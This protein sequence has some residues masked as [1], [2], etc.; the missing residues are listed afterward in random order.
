MILLLSKSTFLRSFTA[1][2]LVICLVFGL[3]AAAGAAS[4]SD[5]GDVSAGAWYYDAV[6]FVTDRGLFNGTSSTSFSPSGTMT[7]GMFITVLGRYAGVD[8]DQWKKAVVSTDQL[9]LRSGP[10][11][12]YAA[13]DTLYSGDAVTLDGDSGGWYQVSAG[14]RSGYVMAEYVT[15]QYHRFSDV[16]YGSYYAGYAIW[17]FEAGIVDGMGSADTFAPSG[18]VTREQ[19]CK[20]LYGY[21]A[22]AGIS[23]P[24]DGS[25]VTFQDQSSVSSWAAEGVSAMQRAG[26]VMGEEKDGGYVFRPGSSATRA[27]AAAIFQRFSRISSGGG[28]TDPTPTPTQAP[29]TVPIPDDTPATFLSDTVPVRPRTVRVGILANTRYYSEAAASVT[30]ENLSGSGFEYGY[31]TADRVFV[32][33]GELGARTVVV[34]SDGT[35]FTV[36]N[37]DGTE[38]YSGTGELAI[39]P[40]DAGTYGTRVNGEYRYRGDFELRQAYNATGYITVINYVDIED[41]V[42]GVLPFEFGSSWPAEA[43]KAGAVTVRNY[44]MSTDWSVYEGFGFDVMANAS[45]Q[46][47]RGRAI[48]YDDSWFSSSDAAVDATANV[49]LT[50]GG[51]ICET[52]YFACDGGATED[53][54]HVWGGTGAS[55]LTGK[56]DPYESSVSSEAPN[57]TYTITNSRTNYAMSQLAA[58]V[59][60][61]NTTIAKNGITV[62]TYPATGNVRSVTITGENGSSV[63]IDQNSGFGR[64]DLLSSLGFTVYSYRYTVTYNPADDSFTC[65]RYGWG[66]L[67]GLSQWGA[68]AMARD[69]GKDYQ[70]ILGFYFDG[71][72]LQYGA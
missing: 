69:Y 2:F 56:R 23:L 44:V 72:H 27:E 8:P 60:L 33:S 21:A 51:A 24:S 41:Y 68:L 55:Y 42:K 47:Y 59:G 7:R 61:G 50:S 53:A 63:T 39:H 46:L 1:V 31:F 10:G 13:L 58:S 9:N 34:T 49:Y 20:L 64:W 54:S 37:S 4:V 62:D 26:V 15:P 25:S 40:V 17:G 35:Y 16:D 22:Y 48:T 28:N 52:H 12:D 43:L 3:T 29:E 18:K 30:L 19:I 67:V 36:T 5:F 45:D 70:T 65:T 66:H 71:T 38:L 14:G 11:L 57:W 32:R 6:S